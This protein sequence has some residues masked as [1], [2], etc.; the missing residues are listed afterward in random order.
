[1]AHGNV[2]L[3]NPTTGEVKLAPVGY[4]WTVLFWGFFPAL[5]RQDWK[6]AGIIIGI[7]IVAGLIFEGA[8]F[9]PLILFSFIY[10]DKMHLKDLLDAGWRIARYSGKK[11]LAVVEQGL[12]Y[13]LDKFMVVE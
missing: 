11:N 4:S 10:N 1:M 5:F 8:G 2:E 9:I 6:N 3:R 12:G 7:A 13:S